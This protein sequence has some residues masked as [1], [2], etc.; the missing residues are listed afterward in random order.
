MVYLDVRKAIKELNRTHSELSTLE[1]NRALAKALNRATTTGRAKSAQETRK[2]YQIRSGDVKKTI[3][4]AKATASKTESSLIS[5]SRSL[6]IYGFGARKSKK[7][8]GVTI[9][10]QRKFFPGA[11]IATM[12]TGHIGVFAR[13]KYV[14][15]KL[16]T[17]R[18]RINEY[19]KPDLPI[20]EVQTL[21]VPSALGNKVVLPNLTKLMQERMLKEYAHEL[22]FRSQRAAGLI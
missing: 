21:S 6:P 17:R 2:I 4:T 1:R 3:G 8:I 11:F 10:G 14:N 18:K 5:K 15:N 19:P 16:V 22:K 9:K 13:A 12:K 20:V 7:G